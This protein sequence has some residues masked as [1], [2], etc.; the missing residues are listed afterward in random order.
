M[1]RK[2]AVNS[3]V[4]SFVHAAT[5]SADADVRVKPPLPLRFDPMRPE[6]PS[7]GIGSLSPS[8]IAE[9][10]R[11]VPA[12]TGTAFL[13]IKTGDDDH[14]HAGW[15]QGDRRY[16]LGAVGRAPYQVEMREEPFGTQTLLQCDGWFGHNV[17]RGASFLLTADGP[18]LFLQTE[19]C[20]IAFDLDGDGESEWIAHTVGTHTAQAYFYK[21][22]DGRMTRA[23]VNAALGAEF[24]L[25]VFRNRKTP[26]LLQAR[27]C[28][29]E[30]AYVY[31]RDG[32][33][34]L[35]AAAKE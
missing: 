10:L 9:V 2:I 5:P 28:G 7:A 14:I 13:F 17:T 19:G 34:E 30:K 11:E 22:C 35:T 33:A 18:Q 3:L 6:E 32:L 16:D 8:K 31:T 20:R 24:V 4:L 26:P 1:L 21:Y 23:D 12:G 15:R 27:V 25:P 29:V